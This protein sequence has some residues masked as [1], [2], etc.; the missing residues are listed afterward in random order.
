MGIIHNWDIVKS[1]AHSWPVCMLLVKYVSHT[2]SC[3][4]GEATV[5]NHENNECCVR[6][7]CLEHHMISGTGEVLPLSCE[8]NV[9]CSSFSSSC[10]LITIG[11]FWLLRGCSQVSAILLDWGSGEH[12]EGITDKCWHMQYTHVASC[13][14]RKVV[15]TP[16]III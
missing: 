8:N 12:S 13:Y 10:R 1:V 11:L 5:H 4:L 3:L 15:C 9:M 2:Y 14:V 7:P 6:P 16:S